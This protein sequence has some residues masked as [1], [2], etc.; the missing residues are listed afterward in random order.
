M[1]DI[2]FKGCHDLVLLSILYT[3]MRE[4]QGGSAKPGSPAKLEG[5]SRV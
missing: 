5:I 4:Y 3:A 1:P 2:Y